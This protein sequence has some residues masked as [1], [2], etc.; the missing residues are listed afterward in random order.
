MQRHLGIG[1]LFVLASLAAADGD[2]EIEQRLGPD[3]ASLLSNDEKVRAQ[4]YE[5]WFL[6][7]QRE[8]QFLVKLAGQEK[9]Q[10]DNA[11][12]SRELAIRM[13]GDLGQ[14]HPVLFRV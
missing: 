6:R 7:R 1:V 3:V 10:Y 9:K 2:Q 8:V 12:D 13:L 4:G 11:F 14:C 5:S